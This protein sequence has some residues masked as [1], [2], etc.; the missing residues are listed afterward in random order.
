MVMETTDFY[1]HVHAMRREF[2]SH[3]PDELV[4]DEAA[5]LLADRWAFAVVLFRELIDSTPD[6]NRRKELEKSRR[7][8]L[9]R[10]AHMVREGMV[11][12]GSPIHWNKL[13]LRLIP[14]EGRHFE[15]RRA[16]PVVRRPI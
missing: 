7:M 15:P 12:D 4:D 11:F 8:Y 6:P 5:G 13:L 16:R 9:L 10:M 3:L 2:M 14:A 1:Q